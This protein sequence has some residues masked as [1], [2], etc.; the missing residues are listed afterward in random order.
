MG[1]VA[2]SAILKTKSHSRK[3]IIELWNKVTWQNVQPHGDISFIPTF[4]LTEFSTKDYKLVFTGDGGDEA[5]AGY[6]K[7]FE[8]FSSNEK[9]Y[10]DK[11]SLIKNDEIFDSLYLKDFSE[12]VNYNEPSKIFTDTI[13]KVSNKDFTNKILY[14]DIAQL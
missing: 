13:N 6:T 4:I 5:F 12:T 3:D 14:F 10:F 9:E 2:I 11:I 1:K 7:Y 8:S